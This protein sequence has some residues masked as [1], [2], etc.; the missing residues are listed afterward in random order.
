M[1]KAETI[2][3]QT[4]IPLRGKVT[5]IFY[6]PS[7]REDWSD[8]ICLYG[9]WDVGKGKVYL[10]DRLDDDLARLGVITAGPDENN[11]YTVKPTDI[12]ILRGEDGKKKTTEVT[13][14]DGA[15]P[16]AAQNA[17]QQPKPTKPAPNGRSD[18]KVLQGRFKAAY[19]IAKDALPEETPPEVIQS[20][21]ACV[22][23]EANKMGIAPPE[24]LTK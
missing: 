11:K 17:P 23:I 5:A 24:T 4:N 3:L 21:T 18:W 14:S 9:D 10:P 22:F 12:T 8:Q 15:T 20:A 2:K 19:A 1:A 16:P 7:K 13:L 6:Q